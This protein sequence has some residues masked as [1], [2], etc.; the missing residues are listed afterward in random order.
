MTPE[1]R[2]PDYTASAVNLCNPPEIGLKLMEL[3]DA[4]AKAR[5]LDANL[6]AMPEYQELKEQEKLATDI[7]AQIR[8]MVEAQGSYQDIESGFY[9][10]KYKRVSKSYNAE[11]FKANYPKESPVV[12]MET[13]NIKALEGLIKGGLLTE[14]DLDN[15]N[16]IERSESYAFYVR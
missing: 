5:T 4:Q 3:Q 13:V 9:A 12:I 1:K 14:Q 16:V 7:T 2:N 6:Q 8:G 10:V 11:R 15:H